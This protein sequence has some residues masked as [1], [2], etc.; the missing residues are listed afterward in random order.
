MAQ[1]QRKI[2]DAAFFNSRVKDAEVGV[3]DANRRAMRAQSSIP[4][5]ITTATYTKAELNGG[6]LDTRYYTE[7]EV[8]A[9]IDYQWQ[10][11]VPSSVTST[12]GTG[13]SRDST[14]GVIT[15]PVSCTQLNVL[16]VFASGYEYMVVTKEQDSFTAYTDNMNFSLLVGSTVQSAGSYY[17]LGRYVMYDGTNGTYIANA[18][19]VMPIGNGYTAGGTSQRR[20]VIL[21]A[22]EAT[23]TV[24]SEIWNYTQGSA[25]RIEATGSYN[26]SAR[27]TGFRL[28]PAT[29]SFG[30]T[31]RVFRRKALI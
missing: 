15:V 25:R 18:A 23:E 29:G 27:A 7:A 26:N 5:Q 22:N 4:G 20:L 10:P 8:A 13:A 30:A 6:Q 12:G 16:G 3:D 31:V 17:T 1:Y 24:V 11:V 14:T 19:T 21:Q 2:D 9:L 28:A